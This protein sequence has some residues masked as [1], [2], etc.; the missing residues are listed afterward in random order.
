MLLGLIVLQDNIHLLMIEAATLVEQEL[1][2][3]QEQEVAQ[4]VQK[5]NIRMKAEKAVVKRVRPEI[6]VLIR[7]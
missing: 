6:I 7:E 2:Q 4:H 3:E 1:I 5:D